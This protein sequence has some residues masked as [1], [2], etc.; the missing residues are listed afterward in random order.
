V[1]K[2][3]GGE[4]AG[5]STAQ[6]NGIVA[7]IEQDL[8]VLRA[9]CRRVDRL[10]QSGFSK[11]FESDIPRVI[12]KMTDV[13]FEE[14]K[15]ARFSFVARIHSWIEDFSQDEIDAF[16]LSY[17]VF[18]QYN[19]RLSI[20]S[21]GRIYSQEWI[22]PRARECFED[23]RSQLNAHLD[24]AATVEFSS[25]QISVRNVVDIIIYGGLAHSNEKKARIFDNW[26]QSGFMGF[27][28]ADFMAYA[29]EAVD[30]L[31][32]LRGLS[33][34][35]VDALETHGLTVEALTDSTPSG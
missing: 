35:L 9:F 12:A 21:L 24:N 33:R 25:G 27:M 5:L 28:W 13:S 1:L 32:Y 20:P 26:E 34:D 18:T 3:Q 8:D 10:E 6:L 14:G 2:I 7:S 19:D 15:D 4:A 30:T 17:R 22:P 31:K 11:R 29:R 23:A 16:V